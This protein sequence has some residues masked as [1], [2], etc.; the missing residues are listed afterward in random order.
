MNMKTILLAL[1]LGCAGLLAA[2]AAVTN[3]MSNGRAW[4]GLGGTDDRLAVELKFIYLVGLADGFRQTQGEITPQEEAAREITPSLLP[5]GTDFP[6][7]IAALDGFYGDSQ[8]L[9]IPIP[10][11]ARY[12]RARLEGREAKQ[13]AES[14]KRLR[15]LSRISKDL[16]SLQKK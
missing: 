5:T 4:K 11:A 12:E 7:M 3:G 10:V 2:D 8:N 13:L 1:T 15:I 16:D 6:T 14:L 9:D